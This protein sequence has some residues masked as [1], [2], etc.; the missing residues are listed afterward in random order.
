M[1]I[2][3]PPA[4]RL[5]S[6]PIFA[7]QQFYC[8]KSNCALS[9][10]ISSFCLN[11]AFRTSVISLFCTILHL[12]ISISLCYIIARKGDTNVLSNSSN[13]TYDPGNA[14]SIEMTHLECDVE[15]KKD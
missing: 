9:T 10:E 2:C 5:H 12:A 4:V 7:P 6:R 14:S 8:I 1:N 3:S 13:R 15:D 11:S